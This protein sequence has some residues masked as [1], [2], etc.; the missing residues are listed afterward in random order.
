MST[1]QEAWNPYERYVQAGLTDG[2]FHNSAFTKLA[3]GP[4]RLAAIGGS[5]VAASL[6][7]ESEASNVVYPLGLIQNIQ[8]SQNNNLMRV[9]EIGS[10]RSYFIPGRT[11]GQLSLGTIYYHGPS[12]LRRMWAY[13]EDSIGPV[14][15]PPLFPN[16]GAA[17]M[18]NPHDVKVPPGYENIYFNLASDLFSQPV[19]LLFYMRDANEDNL[20]ACYM[21][22]VYAPNHNWST[23]A[24][25]IIQQEQVGLQFE[26]V[27][28]VAVSAVP[29]LTTERALAAEQFGG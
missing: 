7:T 26:R 21:E 3:A 15:V 27:V 8:M 5:L 24:Q 25:G 28:P 22:A 1:M 2:K 13:Y 10:Q 20:G 16:M 6:L 18:A 23:D 14:E 19:G 11:A 17:A 12:L 29:L 9:W 4:P